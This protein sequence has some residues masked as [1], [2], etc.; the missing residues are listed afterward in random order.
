[1]TLWELSSEL[2][3]PISGPFATVGFCDASD[4]SDSIVDIRFARLHLSCGVGARYATPIG[5]IR[6]DAGYRIPGM[7]LLGQPDPI[8]PGTL[9]HG[10]PIAFQFGI[11]EAF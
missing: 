10:V 3:V 6:F 4:V 5:P 1:M 8:V 2:R 7:Q 11:G 9:I